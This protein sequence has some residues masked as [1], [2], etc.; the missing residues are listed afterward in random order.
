MT[1]NN[2][3]FVITPYWYN[4]TWVFDDDRV[5]LVMEP[6]V[7]G[8]PDMIDHLVE[9]ISNARQGFR[10]TFSASPFPGHTHS[11]RWVKEESGGNWYRLQ[12]GPNLEGWLCPALFQYI[13]RAPEFL[14]VKA[15]GIVE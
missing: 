1:V 12:E 15:D 2:S 13:E 3:L 6:F 11:L 4:G 5:G 10:M 14:Y 9:D 8:V 7:A